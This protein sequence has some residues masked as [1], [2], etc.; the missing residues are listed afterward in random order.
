MS[1]T[2]SLCN[3]V[4]NCWWMAVSIS[5]INASITFTKI[6]D[7]KQLTTWLDYYWL[8]VQ[9]V[10]FIDTMDN[11]SYHYLSNNMYLDEQHSIILSNVYDNNLNEW[12]DSTNPIHS[13]YSLPFNTTY[14]NNIASG[15][16]STSFKQ[17]SNQITN[18]IIICYENQPPNQNYFVYIFCRIFYNNDYNNS[19]TPYWSNEFIVTP[20]TKLDNGFESYDII[21]FND[22]YFMI[23]EGDPYDYD[24]HS[25]K[26]TLIDLN[27]N[28]IKYNVTIY[29]VVDT[30]Y[31]LSPN[32]LQITCAKFN[33]YSFMI[34]FILNDVGNEAKAYYAYIIG[35]YR[36]ISNIKFINSTNLHF[37]AL[38]EPSHLKNTDEFYVE[39]GVSSTFTTMYVND[40]CCYI[41]PY[42][43]ISAATY[44]K[45]IY[46]TM[47]DK[48]G[49]QILDDKYKN[50]G[51]VL[52]EMHSENNGFY[53]TNQIIPLFMLN[54]DENTKY[55]MSLHSY[56]VFIDDNQH[57]SKSII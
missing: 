33:G 28:I 9:F 44:S 39:Y 54:N 43:L 45:S 10:S 25:I 22:S 12:N 42:Q 17:C 53:Q 15:I 16:S 47:I 34:N 20:P 8:S 49:K 40:D 1:L 4:A 21:C 36:N 18:D 41:L 27:A 26:Y 37:L 32:N 13:Y 2:R 30:K 38:Y 46:Y 5:V 52:I 24:I 14:N 31:E 23:W 6:D 3:T 57:T 29:K 50:D 11:K 55:F 19:N 56:A 7:V 48:N 51:C 35:E